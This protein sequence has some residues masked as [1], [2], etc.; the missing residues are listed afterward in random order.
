MLKP[1]HGGDIDIGI[2]ENSM[3]YFCDINCLKSLLKVP[4]CFKNPDKPTSID[5]IPT[6]WPKSIP[7]QQCF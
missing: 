7:T 2:E 5:L 1:R 3:K 6:N 4:T